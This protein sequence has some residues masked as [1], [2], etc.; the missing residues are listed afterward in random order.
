MGVQPV[1]G[2]KFCQTLAS[3]IDLFYILNSFGDY[4][5]EQL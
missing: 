5:M 3:Y 1:D 2:I 4:L